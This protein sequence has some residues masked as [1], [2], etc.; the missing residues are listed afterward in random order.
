MKALSIPIVVLSLL[1]GNSA[2][3]AQDQPNATFQLAFCNL[4]DYDAVL[5]ALMHKADAQNWTVDGWYPIPDRGC[6]PIGNFLRDKIF[7]FARGSSGAVWRAADND[8]TASV[9]CVDYNKWFRLP[10]VGSASCPAG[11]TSV[12]FRALTVPAS[13]ARLTWTLT[14]TK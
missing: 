3:R 12:R 13:Q 8:Q 1:A 9:Q 14:G 4:S 11:Q 7:Y 6:A 5:V 10:S 2:M